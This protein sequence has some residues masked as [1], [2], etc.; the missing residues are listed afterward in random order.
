MADCNDEICRMVDA[1]NRDEG[2][3]TE[4]RMDAAAQARGMQQA[5]R[6]AHASAHAADAPS[7]PERFSVDGIC[8]SIRPEHITSIHCL[9][10]HLLA[11]PGAR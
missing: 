2:K 4:N 8:S 3:H 1:S 9:L 5:V 7:N 10:H 11:A 6:M